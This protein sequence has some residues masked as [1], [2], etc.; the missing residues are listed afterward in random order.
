MMKKYKIFIAVLAVL[1]FGSCMKSEKADLVVFNANIYTMDESN[2]VAEA[3]AIRDGKILESGPDRQILNKYAYAS[4]ID[5][6]GKQVY[7]GFIDAH[8]HLMS[9]AELLLS[10]DLVGCTSQEDM[11]MRVKDYQ[12]KSNKP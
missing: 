9:Y 1:S 11:V 2:S 7:P 5:A 8:G 10:A 12:S 4:S 6:E 3:M